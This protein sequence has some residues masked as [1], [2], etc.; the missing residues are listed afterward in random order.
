DVAPLTGR[1]GRTNDVSARQEGTVPG[2]AI[3]DVADVATRVALFR[4]ALGAP[5][6]ATSAHERPVEQRP[7]GA[8]QGVTADS[9]E[10]AALASQSGAQA[11]AALRRGRSTE[12]SYAAPLPTHPNTAATSPEH[13]RLAPTEVDSAPGPFAVHAGTVIPAVLVT[14][15]N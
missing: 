8:A 14:E 9:E 15:I 12:P 1:L 5:L 7:P 10:A 6:T 2:E 4:A 11:T 3:S 13:R